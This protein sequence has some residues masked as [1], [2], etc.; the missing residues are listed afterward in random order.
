LE[1]ADKKA[2]LSGL[3]ATGARL[4]LNGMLTRL[5]A[6]YARPKGATPLRVPLVPAYAQC[7]S[8]NRYHGPPDLPGGT[9]PDR[10]CAPPAQLSTQLTVGT[11]D[12]TPSGPAANSS[13]FLKAE[14]LVGN[15]MT[16]ADEANLALSFSITDV[17]RKSDLAD[18]TGQL[19]ARTTL[20]MTDNRSG[21]GANEYGTIQ[22]VPFEFTVPCT[23]TPSTT[24][25]STCSLNTSADALQPGIAVEGARGIW[26]LS[27]VQVADGGADGVAAT[28]PNTIFAKQ[29]IFIP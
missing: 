23:S 17:R 7:T 6:G 4:N 5:S 2:S 12:A 20:R 26:Q 15:P 22:D 25:G 18:Y 16:P 27:Q 10:S 9:N 21:P 3:V 8:V 13:G 11:P 1:G 14:A 29:G 24:I 19:E 28:E